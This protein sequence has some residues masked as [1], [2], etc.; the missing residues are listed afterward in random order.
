MANPI[1]ITKLES[2]LKRWGI[3]YSGYR[4]WKNHNRNHKGAW[5][6][7]NGLMIH[8]T[9]S[10]AA[11]QKPLLYD[12][13]KGLPG[14]LCQFHIDKS[15]KLWLI[16]WGRANHAGG[17]DPNVFKHVVAEDYT[18]ILK[19]KYNESSSGAMDGNARF[20]GVEI[21]YDGSHEMSPAQ[22]STLLKLAA[23]LFEHH[24]W[25][26]KSA[27]GHGEWTNWKW[28]PG[29]S[30]GTMMNMSAVRAD[31]KK[32]LKAGPSVAKPKPAPAPVAKPAPVTLETIN[33]KLDKLIKHFKL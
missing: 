30:K 24:K 31:I 29:K 11:D 7:V 22:Y 33:A 16:G 13:Y 4:D 1:S 18:G 23:A 27:I 26:E 21:A 17:G 3:S 14:P 12:G 6:P 10:E 28:D 5:G 25:N 8:H 19:P 20:Y 2:Q 32:T 9:G 15:G